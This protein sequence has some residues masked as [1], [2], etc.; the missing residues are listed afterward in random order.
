VTTGPTSR[1]HAR[2]SLQRL[3]FEAQAVV[4]VRR[5]DGLATRA[6]A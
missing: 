1:F 5:S 6:G 3:S 4:G 2:G